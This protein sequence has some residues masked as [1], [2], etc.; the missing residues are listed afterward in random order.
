MWLDDGLTFNA[1]IV[2]TFES[3]L[4][5]KISIHL[6]VVHVIKCPF[7]SIQM[8]SHLK[9]EI[10]LSYLL[11]RHFEFQYV[12]CIYVYSIWKRENSKFELKQ[13]KKTSNNDRHRNPNLN[14]WHY[15]WLKVRQSIRS[16]NVR[17][18]HTVALTHK[19]NHSPYLWHTFHIHTHGKWQ[20]HFMCVVM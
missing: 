3:K 17:R 14:H 6:Y 12:Q 4:K 20:P 1:F 8:Y 5:R 15:R 7:I 13:W 18:A 16:S 19:A 9:A 11:F 2:K 10:L